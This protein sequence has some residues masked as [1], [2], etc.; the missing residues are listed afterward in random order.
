[1]KQFPLGRREPKDFEH[2]IKYPI[3]TLI[4]STTERVERILEL[5]SWNKLHNQFNE[6]SCIGF[7]TSM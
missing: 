6:G 1:M 5:P 2:I 4:S 3:R 7:G